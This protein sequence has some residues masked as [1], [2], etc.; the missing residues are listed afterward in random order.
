MVIRAHIGA[1]ASRVYPNLDEVIWNRKRD[2]EMRA[3]F[4]G[5]NYA[6]M[7]ADLPKLASDRPSHLVVVPQVGPEVDTWKAAGGNFF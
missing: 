5:A 3:E 7:L 2:K 1:L 4:A 6:A